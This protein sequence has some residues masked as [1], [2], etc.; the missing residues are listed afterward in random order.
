[1]C[2]IETSGSH[3]ECAGGNIEST[4]GN[5]ESSGNT[6]SA[7]FHFEYRL[8]FGYEL[9]ASLVDRSRFIGGFAPIDSIVVR[10]VVFVNV[11]CVVGRIGVGELR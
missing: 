3:F 4:S 9:L 7:S 11:V 6:D 1:M 8:T 2:G 10:L 5:I